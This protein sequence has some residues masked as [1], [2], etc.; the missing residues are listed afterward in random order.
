MLFPDLR[1]GVS[2]YCPPGLSIIE[3]GF[4][5]GLQ[6]SSNE[7]I[8]SDAW[9]KICMI[10]V[11]DLILLFMILFWLGCRQFTMPLYI[12]VS[13]KDQK[14]DLCRIDGSRVKSYIIS[15]SRFGLGSERGSNKTPLGNFR[16]AEKIGAGAP[17]GEIFVSR[18]ATGRIGRDGD[19]SDHIETR[20]MWLEGL[21][22]DNS[23]TH[24]RYIY[25]H[26][27]NSESRLGT[28]ASYGCIRMGN[29]DIIDLFDQV[30]VGTSVEIHR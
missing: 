15:T 29:K 28:P 1:T 25:I 27:T 12:G 20:I 10:V 2:L 30:T 19:P 4:E 7:K 16:I 8:Q 13:V 24:D 17:E 18:K 3:A 6:M 23:N 14:L 22:H 21:D 26:G 5:F 9:Q 11:F